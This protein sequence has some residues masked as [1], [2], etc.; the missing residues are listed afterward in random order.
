MN[1]QSKPKGGDADANAKQKGD[2]GIFMARIVNALLNTKVLDPA[3]SL[4]KLEETTLAIGPGAIRHLRSLIKEL[5]DMLQGIAGAGIT[6][7]AIADATV[8]LHMLFLESQQ[9][10]DFCL[11]VQYERERQEV[12]YV[13][14]NKRHS[15]GDWMNLISK[16]VEHL[17]RE[18]CTYDRT[19]PED[20]VG[21]R[22]AHELYSIAALAQAA[23]EYLLTNKQKGAADEPRE[24]GT[25]S[26]GRTEEDQGG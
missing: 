26:A 22:C 4:P 23:Y 10:R 13:D 12:L 20:A 17:G 5:I 25:E 18:A 3:I 6:G 14:R 1:Q 16:Q 8:T 2:A 9:A 11:R 19:T 24:S 7:E 21:Q 15:F